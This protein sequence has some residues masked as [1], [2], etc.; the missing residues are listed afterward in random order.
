MCKDVMKECQVCFTIECPSCNRM[1]DNLNKCDYCERFR[2]NNNI[3]DEQW[4]E[5]LDPV[6]ERNIRMINSS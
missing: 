3:T 5:M 2:I 4:N 6:Y 1:E